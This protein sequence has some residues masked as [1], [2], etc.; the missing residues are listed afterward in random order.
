[1]ADNKV[2]TA[3]GTEIPPFP[4]DKLY[5]IGFRWVRASF[6]NDVLNWQNVERKPGQYTIDAGADAAITDYAAHGMTVVM[7]LGAGE[8]AQRHRWSS[9]SS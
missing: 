4:P 3:I 8:A 7:T 9:I 6:G 5:P 2:G 1:M